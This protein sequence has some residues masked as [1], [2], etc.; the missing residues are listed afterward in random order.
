V[1]SI[2]FSEYCKVVKPEYVYL[3]L[4]PNNSIRNNSTNR[5]AKAISSLYK[6]IWQQVKIEEGKIIKAF[7]K[8]FMI[9][10]K[11]S[12]HLG[13]KVSYLIY[14]EKKQVGFYFLVPKYA[15]S[16]L[17]EKI[18]DAWSNVTIERVESLPEFSPG[19]TKYQMVYS[20]EDGLSLSTDRRSN[21]LLHSNLNIVEVLE[22]GD[23]IGVF[24][25]FIPITQ[26]TWRATYRN[27]IQKVRDGTPV[28]RNKIGLGFWFKM[29]VAFIGSIS[30]ALSDVTRDIGAKEQHATNASF[31]MMEKI[32]ERTN[33]S[34]VANSTYKK[35]ADIVLNTQILVI[36]ES[37]NKMR[38]RN[39]AKSVAQSFE[40]ISEDNSLISK[41]YTKPFNPL[42]FSLSKV[43]VNKISA[44]ECQN[45]I[46]LP[47][48]ELL[49]SYNFIDK[50]YTHETEVPEE[51]RDGIM[52]V[53]ENTFRG[54]KQ[55]AYLSTDRE[56][57]QLTLV[58]I[59]PTRAGKSTLIG[60]LANDAL[61][62]GECVVM[63]DFIENCE[64][65]S[66]I[67]ALFP[68]EKVL[69]IRCN[70]FGTLQGLGY[71]EVGISNDIFTQYDNAKKQATQLLALINSI[72]TNDKTLPPRMER[73]LT[74]ASLVAF[75]QGGSVMD[76]FSI[77]TDHNCRDR[78]VKGVPESQ[79][80][81]M[82][83]Y[84]MSL[85]ELDEI[86]TNKQTKQDY[87]AG[88]KFNLITGISD[89]L[90][91][92]KANTYMELMLK[93]GIENNINLVKE[94]Q[95]PQLICIKMPESMF[96]TDAERDTYCTYWMT[97]LWLS[98]QIRSDQIR[99][100]DARTKVNLIIDEL[101]QVHNTEEF[102]TEKL[103]RLAKF[104]LKP[105]ISCHY[106]NQIS[107]IRDELRSANAS[108]MLISG[109]DKQN[110]NELKDELY[111]YQLEDL[112]N[113]PR[114]HSLNLIKSKGGYAKFITK[115]PK[116]IQQANYKQ[117]AK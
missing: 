92:L 4:T 90:Q 72:N 117:A 56:Y 53:G 26:F 14:I 36:S 62:N 105:I 98:L 27:T 69:N 77:L 15:M 43:E 7:G 73:F 110:Y 82:S 12:L 3:K 13:A 22:D 5:I 99:D 111:P 60:N 37:Q 41:S 42:A 81:N 61:N 23:K 75:I 103:S 91:K 2:K 106:M 40:T 109:C 57:Q 79:W 55:K 114:Y 58:L 107:I 39:N 16:I 24:Y 113:L 49:E 51:L 86:A 88:T 9:G 32:V 20:K 28:D 93:R 112:L 95:K 101:Y 84:I 11:Y 25:N 108:Y 76:V 97:K 104:R 67:E 45:F 83:E 65:S 70:D 38:E 71:N 19:S 21:E 44:D 66:E 78:F 68:A 1:K 116:P 18:R 34:L 85:G 100:K 35:G 52:S 29:A 94:I 96:A 115:L 8:E 46:S 63:F 80:E 17:R 102:L 33:R 64:L 10:T 54:N 59:G 47:G 89:R 31:R 48:R 30:T 50:V 74:S 6:T 87:V